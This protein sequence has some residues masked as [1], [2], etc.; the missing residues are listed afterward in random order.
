MGLY[1][2]TPNTEKLSQDGEN[3]NLR[4]GASAMQGWR[5]SMEDAVSS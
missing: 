2:S 4:Y 1:L 5:T 3:E